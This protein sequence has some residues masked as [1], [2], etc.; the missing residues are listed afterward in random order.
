MRVARQLKTSLLAFC[1]ALAV[2]ASSV[3]AGFQ[4]SGTQLLDGNGQPFVMRGVNH[5]HTWFTSQ[6]NSAI[7]NIAAT[8]ANTVRVVLS[9]GDQWPKVP[10]SQVSNIINLCKNNKLI[11]MLEIHDT[12]GYGD[13]G[14]HAPNA[15][16]VANAASYWVEIANTLKGQE[17]YV[18]I[19]I[20]NEPFGNGPSADD[21]VNAHRSAIQRLRNAGLTHTLVV[22][23]P[24]WGQDWENLMAN[25]AS[26]VAEA[27]SLNNTIFSVHMYEVYQ[28]YNKVRSYISG[29]LSRHN[30]PLIVGEFG[31]N[32]QGN[33]VDADSI[34]EV[35]EEFNIGYL[36]WSWSGNGSCCTDLDIVLNW[37]ANNYS[38]W[39]NRLM[40]SNNGIR[41]T[42]V[43]ASVYSGNVV[44]S[45]SSVA[46]SSSAANSSVG[47]Q[48]GIAFNDFPYCLQGSSTDPD[49]DGW[50]W[51]NQKS[52]V[53]PNSP[54]DPNPGS[55]SLGGGSSSIA[56]SSSAA[57]SSSSSVASSS[58]GSG[59]GDS[60]QTPQQPTRAGS[61][62]EFLLILFSIAL[63]AGGVLRRVKL[64]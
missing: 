63:L 44:I 17:D 64:G 31:D 41:N 22:D 32:H 12:T 15:G 26:R 10:A 40:T 49:G 37:N 30:L 5:A 60:N 58:V 62:S 4:V 55:C 61:V 33:F 23:A 7:P 21:W 29:F 46:S 39:G 18:L 56:S 9:N 54:A 2:V 52:C 24:N 19:N 45:S 38:P 14:G 8:G 16:T 51:E 6:T 28:D 36:G 3:H 48:C 27:D 59:N 1:G 34:M 42:S 57:V 43:L 25:N 47:G 11:C 35:A 13:T 50:G 20:A 53:V